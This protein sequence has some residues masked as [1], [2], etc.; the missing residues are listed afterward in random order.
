M[1]ARSKSLV[2]QLS[3]RIIGLQLLAVLGLIV[4]VTFSYHQENVSYIDDSVPRVIQDALHLD[5]SGHLALADDKDVQALLRAQPGL[6]F[7]VEDEQGRQ[8]EH[9]EVPAIY[10]PLASSL[11]HLGATEIHDSRPPYTLTM[12][13][14][15]GETSFGQVHIMCGGVASVKLG[16]VLVGVASYLAWRMT[17]P[18]ILATLVVMPWL[19]RRAISGVREVAEQARAINIDER[20]ARL[21][22]QAVPRELQ[23]MVQAFNA[24]L[25]RLNEG[26]EARDR[27]LVDAA[28]ELRAPIAILEARIE[29]LVAG[30]S[31]SRLLADVARLSNLAEQL[32]DLQR[33]SRPQD[34]FEPLDLVA[35]SSE[36][37]ADVAPMVVDAGYELALDA[38]DAHVMVMGDR[39]ALSRALTNLLQNAIAHGGG[40]GVITIVVKEDGTLG[41]SDQ[42]P[43]VPVDERHRIFDPFYRLR[44]S[45][46]GAGLG[47]HLVQEIIALHRGRVEVTEADGGGACFRLWLPRCGDTA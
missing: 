45:S 42:G 28:H 41:V 23:P 36:V 40:R 9:G 27:F 5:S 14:R 22:D 4:V 18:L 47:L 7:V 8:L 21:A 17:L 19:I 10:R 39:M 38:P 43:G 20:S 46:T 44:P 11:S 32:L 16:P 30:A 13:T 15:L 37:A 3:W 2:F 1:F 33:L 29:T 26:Y 24:A 25:E 12:R 35:L 34:A 6:W 31:R